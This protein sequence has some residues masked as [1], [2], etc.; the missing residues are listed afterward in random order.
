MTRYIVDVEAPYWVTTTIR[1]HGFDD[2]PK[3]ESKTSPRFFCLGYQWQLELSAQYDGRTV[4]LNLCDRSKRTHLKVYY[5]FLNDDISAHWFSGT[6]DNHYPS[7]LLKKSEASSHVRNGTLSIQIRLTTD[8][9]H[10]RPQPQTFIPSNPSACKT[11]QDSFMAED[12]ADVVIEIGEN[13]EGNMSPTTKFYAHYFILKRASPLLAELCKSSN[14][15]PSR[16]QLSN[17]SPDNFKDMLLYIYGFQI[18]AFGSNSERTKKIIEIANKYGVTNLKIEAEV[19]YVSSL[20]LSLG[21]ISEL[22]FF[23]ESMNC[24]LLKEKALEF[25]V[26]NAVN[27]AEKKLLIDAPASLYNDI[28]LATALRSKTGEGIDTMSVNE[29]RRLSHQKGL[30]IDGTR[31]MLIAGLQQK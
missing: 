15:S 14:D 19:F 20:S 9:Y 8:N 24:A 1:F 25:I 26:N 10:P 21:N 5:Q 7:W 6:S 2:L 30:A 13:E 27:V 4:R 31:E 3:S 11:I 17:E 28:L 12:S 16:V 29:L 18:P 23:A 22:L